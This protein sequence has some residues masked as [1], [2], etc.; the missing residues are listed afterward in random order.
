MSTCTWSMIRNSAGFITLP[1]AAW[2]ALGTLL[3]VGALS[4]ACYIQTSR[5]ASL[6]AEYEAFKGGVEALGRAAKKAAAEKEAADKLRK[7]Q[8]DALH[9]KAVDALNADIRR[10]RSDSARGRRLPLPSTITAGTSRTCFDSDRLIAAIRGLDEN[11][12]GIVEVGA[13]AVVD[14]DAAKNWAQRR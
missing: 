4:G 5:L 6:R 11:L 14:L 1:L 9:L 13:K 8:A 12:L 2:G 10:L 7:E 3:V